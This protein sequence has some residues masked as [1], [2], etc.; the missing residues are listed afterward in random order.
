MERRRWRWNAFETLEAAILHSRNQR[1]SLCITAFCSLRCRNSRYHFLRN[2]WYSRVCKLRGVSRLS[3]SLT[4]IFQSIYLSAIISWQS[5]DNVRRFGKIVEINW[6]LLKKKLNKM[7]DFCQLISTCVLLVLAFSLFDRKHPN[8][9]TP[10]A[11]KMVFFM[12]LIYIRAVSSI[13]RL[14]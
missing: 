3:L 4:F 1:Y 12:K 14:P 13:L 8:N 10:C 5:L 7:G 11:N 6:I 2:R 9:Q